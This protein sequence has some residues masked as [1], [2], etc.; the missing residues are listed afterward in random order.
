[1]LGFTLINFFKKLKQKKS[2]IAL[3]NGN[4]KEGRLPIIITTDGVSGLA[5]NAQPY[6]KLDQTLLFALTLINILVIYNKKNPQSR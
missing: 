1:L 6:A 5:Q 2:L 4:S 3:V